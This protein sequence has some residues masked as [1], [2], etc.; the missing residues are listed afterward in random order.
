MDPPQPPPPV[1]RLIRELRGRGLP[2]VEPRCGECGQARKLPYKAGGTRICL[3]CYQ[4]GK[5]EKCSICSLEKPVVARRD[6][7]TPICGVCQMQIKAEPCTRCAEVRPVAVRSD[8][9][10]VCHRCYSRPK[11]VCSRCGTAA[12]AHAITSDG[13][14]CDHCY[15][16]APRTCGYCGECERIEVAATGDAPDICSKC[17]RKPLPR[18]PDCGTRAPCAHDQEYLDRPGNAGL[19]L[20]V[21]TLAKRRRTP[22]R[23]TRTCS[24][25]SRD[26]PAQAIWPC[27]PVCSTCYDAVL[28]HPAE[29]ASCHKVG[30]LIGVG[31]CPECSGHS[32]DYECVECH[33][34]SR[35]IVE[36][37]CERCT[38]R[39]WLSDL[40]A[41][42]D[43]DNPITNL[44]TIADTT[45]SPRAL[46]AWLRHSP[47]AEWIRQLSAAETYPTHR[48]LDELVAGKPGVYFRHLLVL[49][50]VLPGRDEYTEENGPWL[51]SVI[52]PG[53][54]GEK[55]IQQF[56]QWSVFRRARRR[57]RD[58]TENSQRWARQRIL[59]ARDFL[60]WLDDRGRALHE[61]RQTDIDLWLATG[62]TRRYTIR[63]FI[64]WAQKQHHLVGDRTVPL[65]ATRSVMEQTTADERWAILKRLLK[66]DSLASDIRVAGTL[67][68]LFAQHVSR[69][70][71]LRTDA[72]DSLLN[73]QPF[74]WVT[75]ASCCPL[76]SPPCCRSCLH[77]LGAGIQLSRATKPARD[78]CSRA[79]SPGST[80]L[81]NT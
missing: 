32:N 19:H 46:V 23:A 26:L 81:R 16:S 52:T 3:P 59:V 33:T 44:L 34:P 41:A 57:R 60:T 5:V 43:P 51:A 42:A 71:M 21:I 73:R 37:R 10:P 28:R 70:V 62:S 9:G 25:C 74:F 69:V 38:A 14:V 75:S 29:C 48:Q 40:L 61:C 47:G 68:L 79:A 20:D 35:A 56:A 64:H 49:S 36:G 13:P 39:R 50:G 77:N 24:V 55:L 63:D 67:V 45:D 31:T 11:H 22:P 17:Y 6:D 27:G 18:C 12:A 78:G 30:V 72:V 2:A 7:G 1:I 58:A 15:R 80:S 53:H 54:P 66:D 76:L 4:R 8:V 65:R